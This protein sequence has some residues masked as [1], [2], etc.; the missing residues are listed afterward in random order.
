MNN[1]QNPGGIMK[2]SIVA[3]L[4]I[5]ASGLVQASDDRVL[6]AVT[7]KTDG[8]VTASPSFVATVGQA[9]SVRLADGLSI[10][11]LTKEP[12]PDGRSWT[13]VRI[14]YFEASDSK[15]V[16]ERSM[17]HTLAEG[18]SIEFTEPT[19]HKRFIVVVSKAK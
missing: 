11:A 18:G 5:S 1:T 9:A 8:V 3:A 15:F 6:F 2:T 19:K 13:Q 7:E 14:T 16:Q 17:R 12:E 10:E 4:L